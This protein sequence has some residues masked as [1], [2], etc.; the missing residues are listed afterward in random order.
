MWWLSVELVMRVV[1]VESVVR[2]VAGCRVGVI[3]Y[4]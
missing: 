2:V 4:R 3:E 1:A